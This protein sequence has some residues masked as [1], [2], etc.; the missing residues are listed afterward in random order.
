MN[1]TRITAVQP[2]QAVEGGRVSVH[3]VGFPIDQPRLP[4]VSLSDHPAR[5]VYAST[6]CLDII[7]PSGF[8]SGGS[9][10]VR[11]DGESSDAAVIEVARPVAT[12]LHQVD[13]PVCDRVGN[14]YVTFSGRRGQQVPVSIFRIGSDGTRDAFARGVTNATSLAIDPRGRLYVSSRFE[15][16]VYRLDED[17]NA[18]PFATD[19]GVPCGLAFSRDGALYVGDRSGTIFRVDE[20][21]RA[22]ALASL[23][24]SVAAFHLALG[25]DDALYVTG[26]TL[27]C[28]DAVY[29]VSLD[30]EVTTL[31]EAFGRPQGLAFDPAGALYVVDALAGESGVYRL[32]K[33][34]ERELVV[35]GV[36]LIGVAFDHHGDMMVCSADSLYRLRHQAS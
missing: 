29:R 27:A 12:D 26:P 16:T 21:G 18:R 7:V 22:L 11:I 6:T 36:D 30:G 19:L 24:P 32:P 13:N 25:P 1:Q 3:G 34:R 15:G 2:R 5:V 8:P 4:E 9:F 35:A 17:G 31:S 14:V 23:P 33:E 28:R 10:A 20:E